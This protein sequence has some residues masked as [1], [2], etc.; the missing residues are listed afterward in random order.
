MGNGL[1]HVREEYLAA[2]VNRSVQTPSPETSFLN[3]IRMCL[4]GQRSKK[5]LQTCIT[6]PIFV[7]ITWTLSPALD[8]GARFNEHDPSTGRTKFAVVVIPQKT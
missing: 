7:H 6:L 2:K 8:L 4:W 5:Y 1:C 3:K